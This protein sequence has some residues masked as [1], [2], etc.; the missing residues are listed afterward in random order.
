MKKLLSKLY[1]TFGLKN[2]KPENIISNEPLNLKKIEQA[3]KIIKELHSQMQDLASEGY[4][5]FVAA[6]YDQNGNLIAKEANSVV[7]EVCSN[8]HAEINAI[9]KAQEKLE[10]YDLSSYNLSIY[11]TAEPCMMCIGAI[12][13]SGI[14]NVYYSVPSKT[15]EKI[16][17][18][19]E[20][21][22]P[23]WLKEFKKRGIIVYG[24]IDAKDG[25][26]EL[27][28]YVNS[29]KT[30]YKPGLKSTNI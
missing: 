7:N 10:T 21:F 9:K 28:Q 27:K 29:G 5:P 30:I 16:T 24:N 23:S 15:V 22:K 12:M 2:T 18:F 4:G 26:F 14:K 19:D 17:G 6:V 25:E 1:S 3:S 13:W 20:G 11:I 8:N